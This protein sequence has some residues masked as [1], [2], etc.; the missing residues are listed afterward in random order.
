MRLR[1]LLL[2]AM[3]T[4][5]GAL[6]PVPVARAAVSETT[7]HGYPIRDHIAR[8]LDGEII[9]APALEGALLLTT[10]GGDYSLQLGQDLAIGYL[11]HDADMIELYLQ[12]SLTFLAFTAEASVA[13]LPG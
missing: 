12:E 6:P 8:L 11:S 13:L 9:W 1:P 3:L 4:T 2:A 7:D 10:R 5:S